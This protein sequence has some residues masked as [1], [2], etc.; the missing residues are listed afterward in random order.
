[1]VDIPIPTGAD[2]AHNIN[3]LFIN[4]PN[5][6]ITTSRP[7][8]SDFYPP[9]AFDP[10]LYPQHHDAPSIGKKFDVNKPRPSLLPIDAVMEIVNV[11]EFG[12]KK[13]GDNNWQHVSPHARYFDA[14]LRHLFAS[15]SG[16]K[17][18]PESG[19][20]HFAHAATCLLFLLHFELNG[21][22]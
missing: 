21:K 7:D 9:G 2:S 8:I 16:E 3:A 15:Q 10:G 17:F 22:I 6:Q 14:A 1:M 4:T 20:S 5:K 11:L 13:Y 12:A 18:D 19:L